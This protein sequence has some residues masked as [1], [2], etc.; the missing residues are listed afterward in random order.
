MVVQLLADLFHE[1][2]DAEEIED[3]VTRL[4]RP[5]QLDPGPIVV[6]VKR[7]TLAIAEEHEV[8]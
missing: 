6:A 2:L 4:K 1:R 3:I 8:A 5:F 7:L